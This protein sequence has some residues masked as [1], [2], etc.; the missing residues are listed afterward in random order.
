M[1]KEYLEG[2]D[3]AT[4]DRWV[5]HELKHEAF[6][7][8]FDG[9]GCRA[10]NCFYLHPND[11]YST[12]DKVRVEVWSGRLHPNGKHRPRNYGWVTHSEVCAFL[13]FPN[14][15]TGRKYKRFQTLMKEIRELKR[16][17]GFTA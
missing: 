12:A 6:S 7:R 1:N 9:L 5:E 8:E 17:F 10:I 15:Q 2:M 3:E 14:P 13:G 4:K 16:E 11:E